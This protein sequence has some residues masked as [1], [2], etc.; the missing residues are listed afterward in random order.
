MESMRQQK[1]A[2]LIQKDIGD[3]FSREGSSLSGGAMITV[4][5]VKVT[6][7]LSLARVYL[8]IF[9]PGKREGVIDKINNKKGEIRFKLGNKVKNQ[10]RK[11]PDLEFFEDDSLDYIENIE[12]LLNT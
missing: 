7:D 5:K 8:S 4:T 9:P 10:L 11:V 12:N 3:I 6:S 1:I 2:R